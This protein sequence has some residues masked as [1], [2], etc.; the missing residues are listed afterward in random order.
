MDLDQHIRAKA[1]RL[2]G[3]SVVAKGFGEMVNQRFRF[4]RG[5]GIEEARAA[6]LFRVCE[7][8]KLADDKGLSI[9]FAQA[10]VESSGFVRKNAKL[11]D[12]FRQVKGV[13]CR[14]ALSDSGEDTDPSTDGRYHCAIDGD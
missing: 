7:K 12:S 8:R 11:G 1:P 14:I 6:A 4:V 9:N 13:F 2:Y 5:S 10:Q 3:H